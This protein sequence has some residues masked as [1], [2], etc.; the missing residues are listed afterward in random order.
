MVSTRTKR[1]N[2]RRGACALES[3]VVLPVVLFL[4]FS[5]L[6]LALATIRFNVLAEGSRRIARQ[7]ILH[8]SLVSSQ[9][10]SWGPAPFNGT[11]DDDSQLCTPLQGMLPTMDYQLVLVRVEWLDGDNSP[12]DR[13]LVETSYPHRT[14]IPFWMKD[15]TIRSSTT[16]HIVN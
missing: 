10:E 2:R 15:L 9:T 11:A 4:L 6:D 8:G 13:I 5:M 7:A 3:A 16:M 14:I 12:G 1:V